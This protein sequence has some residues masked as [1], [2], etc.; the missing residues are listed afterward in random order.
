MKGID[1]DARIHSQVKKSWALEIPALL[2]HLVNLLR[3]QRG[4]LDGV[5]A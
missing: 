3:Y 2:S 5:L 1:Y 4:S